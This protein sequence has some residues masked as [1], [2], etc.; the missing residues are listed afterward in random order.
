MPWLVLRVFS[1]GTISRHQFINSTVVKSH[2][3][4]I[5]TEVEVEIYKP[6]LLS[7]GEAQ[8]EIVSS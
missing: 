2:K 1:S 5:S 4:S 6:N 7:V 3:S 8:S